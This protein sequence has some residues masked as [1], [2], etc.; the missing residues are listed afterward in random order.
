MEKGIRLKYDY[1][2]CM[3]IYV[4]NARVLSY[5]P[6]NQYLNFPVLIFHLIANHEYV[7][8]YR[9]DGSGQDLG[10]PEDYE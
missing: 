4:F 1:F 5:I 10:C 7:R 2:V 8:G 6:H 3:G 9:Y